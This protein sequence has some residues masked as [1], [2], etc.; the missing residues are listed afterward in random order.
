MKHL[1]RILGVSWW[2]SLRFPAL[3]DITGPACVVDGG[4]IDI[5]GQRIRFHGIDAPESAQTCVAD[6]ATW[7][8]GQRATD[9]LAAFIGGVPV[10]CEEQVTD[11][12][13]RM[14]GKCYVQGEDIEARMVRDGWALAYRK[15]SQDY[16]SEEASAQTARVGLWQ[17]KFVRPWEWRKGE[18]LKA[19]TALDNATGCAIK[20]D[21]SPSGERIHHVS[22]GKWYDHAMV[23]PE[24]GERWFLYEAQ[25]RAER[26]KDEVMSGPSAGLTGHRELSI[27]HHVHG[28]RVVH[29]HF[30]P[31]NP[32]R[33]SRGG[34]HNQD[35]SIF[36]IVQ[37]SKTKPTLLSSRPH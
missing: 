20:G 9:V 6:G 19:A 26:E 25:T 22:D 14:I 4:S 8:C 13:G 28:G 35:Q 37:A 15:Y 32:I 31:R 16:V 24:K 3:A 34:G 1:L 33:R 36:S 29:S 30:Q 11:R 23:S 2:P 5:N 7:P 12:Y 17:G 27:P 21:I 18:R 10:R